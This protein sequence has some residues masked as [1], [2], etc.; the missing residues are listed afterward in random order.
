MDRRLSINQIAELAGC[1][2]ATISRVI[3]NRGGY[4]KET[5]EKVERL[6]QEYNYLPNAN[7]SGLRTKRSHSIG[8]MVPD[9]TNE[10]F[11]KII[12]EL[13]L[14]FLKHNYVLLICDS[15][16]DSRLENMHLDNLIKKNV[17]GII[18]ISGQDEIKNMGHFTIPVVYVDRSPENAEVVIHS[19]N[20]QGGYLAAK[21]L[22]SKG[23]KRILFFGDLRYRSPVRR[24]R[25]GYRK[26]L[27]EAG[28]PYGG[29]LEIC[30]YPDYESAKKKMAE[31]LREKG[32]YFDGVFTTNDMMALG[33]IHALED[34]GYKV[35]DHV[36]VVGFDNISMSEFCN[37]P[38]TTIAQDTKGLAVKSGEALMKMIQN[39]GRL[40]KK[41]LIIPVSLK[42]RKSTAETGVLT[43]SSES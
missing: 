27:E 18:Y 43:Y 11:A 37:P 25:E 1:S 21:E 26:A 5:Q 4:S 41:K 30:T 2:V 16:E 20:V 3:N 31:V 34:N 22:A 7:A 15:N 14:F 28:L 19:D 9:I 12:R 39:K 23:C 24:R 8:V 6:I 32:C 38:I 17:D 42:D 10:F 35:P 40:K 33:T 36:K 29:D 13:D